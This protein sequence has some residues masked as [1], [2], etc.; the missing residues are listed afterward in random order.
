VRL[1]CVSNEANSVER[2]MS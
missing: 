1:L 2:K